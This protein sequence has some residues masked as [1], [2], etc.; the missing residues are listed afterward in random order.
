[1]NPVLKPGVVDGGSRKRWELPPNACTRLVW[2]NNIIILPGYSRCTAAL[3]AQ[4]TLTCRDTAPSDLG[5]GD[6]CQFVIKSLL[7]WLRAI[8]YRRQGRV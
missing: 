4:N 6:W 8:W 2:Y 3:P 7:W 5:L 1:M